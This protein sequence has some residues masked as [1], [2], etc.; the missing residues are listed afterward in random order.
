[1]HCARGNDNMSRNP[2]RDWKWQES[3]PTPRHNP[4]ELQIMWVPRQ[5]QVVYFA[6]AFVRKKHMERWATHNS[7]VGTDHTCLEIHLPW[8]VQ[9]TPC[10]F[11]RWWSTFPC[12]CPSCPLATESTS[13]G[14]CNLGWTYALCTV[15]SKGS[16]PL[17]MS[18]QR[19]WLLADG[20]KCK[21]R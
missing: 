17:E 10:Q 19:G 18:R 21:W 2:L 9:F 1:M 13:K 6:M 20:T 3:E 16:E 14:C 8:T 4:A 15:A 7:P 12:A 5:T 11:L